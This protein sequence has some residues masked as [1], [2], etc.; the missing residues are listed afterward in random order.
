[1][2]YRHLDGSFCTPGFHRF[3]LGVP[4]RVKASELRLLT[5]RCSRCPPLFQ[6]LIPTRV[7]V[8]AA[9]SYMSSPD[10]RMSV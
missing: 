5:S 9:D 8:G 2:G 1:M 6:V 3:V 7:L 10:S 4:A